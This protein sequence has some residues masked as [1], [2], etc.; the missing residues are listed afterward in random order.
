MVHV[1]SPGPKVNR[2]DTNKFSFVEQ[3]NIKLSLEQLDNSY[4]LKKPWK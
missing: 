3:V 1:I 2:F 4:C